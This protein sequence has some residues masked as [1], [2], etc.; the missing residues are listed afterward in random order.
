MLG[1]ADAAPIAHS[2]KKSLQRRFAVDQ[3][4]AGHVATVEIKKIE[5]VIDKTIVATILQVGLQQRKA[6]HAFVAL[7]HQFAVEQ[8][9]FGRQRRNRRGNRLEALCPIEPL[10]RQQLDLAVVE[11]RLDAVAIIFDLVQPFPAAR[12]SAVQGGKAGRDEIRK[13][14]VGNARASSP[15]DCLDGGLGISGRAVRVPDPLLTLTGGDLLDRTAGRGGLRLILE[16]I[17]VARPARL[18]V[19]A[20]DLE[21][22]VVAVARL[23]AQPH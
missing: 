4:R 22:V 7:H 16:N 23:R 13:V 17:L 11:P 14:R 1:E 9:G 21:P 10:A 19:L 20:L 2:L 15:L 5:D 3:R 6:R 18:V 12:R 8:R